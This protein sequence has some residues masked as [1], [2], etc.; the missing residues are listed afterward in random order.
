MVTHNV[1]IC[2]QRLHEF[3][4]VTSSIMLHTHTARHI[5][6]ISQGRVPTVRKIEWY[7]V[8][9]RSFYETKLVCLKLGKESNQCEC[10]G[11]IF[12]RWG[13]KLNKYWV[14]DSSLRQFRF[15]R[16]SCFPIFQFKNKRLKF[17]NLWVNY[18]NYQVIC[19][20]VGSNQHN[21]Q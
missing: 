13:S 5:M 8:W 10:S 4:C 6:F 15:A 19:I 9:M 1:L 21:S 12:S 17:G 14:S 18:S 3:S 2:Q 20:Q 16:K 11:I 7:C